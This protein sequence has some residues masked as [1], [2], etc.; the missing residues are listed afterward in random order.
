MGGTLFDLTGKCAIVTGGSRGIG[1]AI[2]YRLAEHGARVIIASRDEASCIAATADIDER[3]GRAAT[4]VQRTDLEDIAD[5]EAL[6][7]RARAC[8]GVDI[9]MCS[10][11]A[12]FH[13][14][15][16]AEIDDESF[17]RTFRLNVLANNH[18]VARVAPQ[19]VAKGGGSVVIL[20]SIG[21]LRANPLNG[22][23]SVSKA[24][25][26]Q[27]VRSLALELGS[28]NIRVNAILPGLVR[29]DMS[30]SL[31]EDGDRE[32]AYAARLPIKRIGEPDDIA[33][34]AVYL[35]SPASAWTTGQN[36]PVDGGALS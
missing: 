25:D 16:L 5:I 18:L 31:W 17:L 9:L 35:A 32:T 7:D 22:A 13:L 24:A 27:L 19:M 14:G 15:P 20:S 2:A 29:T 30:R 3:L 28:D 12:S 21:A 23:Y 36:F 10:A 11:A 8:G 26:L 4:I 33:G 6:A 34:M 1:K